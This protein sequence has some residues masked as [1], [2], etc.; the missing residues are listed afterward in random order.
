MIYVDKKSVSLP[1]KKDLSKVLHQLYHYKCGYCE[2]REEQMNIE[3]YRPVSIYDWLSGSWDNL[4]LS[5][6]KCNTKKSAKFP[7]QNGRV[8]ESA[9]FKKRVH[10]C[11]KI[12]DRIEKPLLLNPE[13]ETQPEQH[14]SFTTKGEI[15]GTTIRGTETIAVCDLNRKYLIEKRKAIFDL[16]KASITEYKLANNTVKIK[17]IV[18]KF[19]GKINNPNSEFLA[20]QQ[21]ILKYELK[22]L[23]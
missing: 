2:Q 3:H 20:F 13:R 10:A 23:Y 8:V 12:Y 9:A 18:E 1:L 6:P 17:E 11:G 7:T 22:K 19:V 21:Y 16:L 14:L 15:E 5:C 4:V